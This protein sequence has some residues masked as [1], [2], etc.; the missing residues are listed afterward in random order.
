M[1]EQVTLT[2]TA[3]NLKRLVKYLN[4]PRRALPGK[5]VLRQ[6]HLLFHFHPTIF[7]SISAAQVV[8]RDLAILHCNPINQA[9][10]QKG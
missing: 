9:A 6:K 1:N 7:K 3:Q 2:A 4:K 10:L 8:F 5:G